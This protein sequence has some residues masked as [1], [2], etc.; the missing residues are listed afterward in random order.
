[1][2]DVCATLAGFNK[3]IEERDINI[4]VAQLVQ[5]KGYFKNAEIKAAFD[6]AFNGELDLKPEDL[7][8]YGQ[9]SW[10]YV[11]RILYAYEKKVQGGKLIQDLSLPF[12]QE[13]VTPEQILQSKRYI[14]DQIIEQFTRGEDHDYGAIGNTD[15]NIIN[16]VY[17][18]LN[19]LGYK[20]NEPK[21]LRQLYMTQRANEL[22]RARYWMKQKER[23][24]FSEYKD[25]KFMAKSKEGMNRNKVHREV[26]K[27]CRMILVTRFYEECKEMEF[28]LAADILERF[29]GVGDL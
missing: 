1:M 28:D 7:K 5:N 4:L 13:Q 21:E 10:L 15:L 29:N 11:S 27:R 3:E 16:L 2:V 25:E 22:E 14:I 26:A 23:P 9:F 6:C 12:E 19:G 24:A 8:P 20:F 18:C 17:D